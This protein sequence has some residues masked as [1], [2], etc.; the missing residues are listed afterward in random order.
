[1]ALCQ[2]DMDSLSSSSSSLLNLL[3]IV[4]VD[5]SAIDNNSAVAIFEPLSDSCGESDMEGLDFSLFEPQ[6]ESNCCRRDLHVYSGTLDLLMHNCEPDCCVTDGNGETCWEPC[7]CV[8]LQDEQTLTAYR[9][10]DM[11]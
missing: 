3:N 2:R 1:M 6:V 8:L 7:Y 11:A 4:E 10:E 5:E 9:S